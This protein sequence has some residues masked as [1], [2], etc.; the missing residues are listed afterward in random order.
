MYFYQKKFR[1]N[2]TFG[3]QKQIKA[4]E[5]ALC[6]TIQNAFKTYCDFND[7]RLEDVEKKS[8]DQR[9]KILGYAATAISIGAGVASGVTL[10]AI[11][12]R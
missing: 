2:A 7:E 3:T 10:N 5:S 12:R 11:M 4:W 1:K 8:R 9:R 6:E